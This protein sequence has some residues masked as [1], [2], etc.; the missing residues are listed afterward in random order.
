MRGFIIPVG[1]AESKIG[2]PL[3][4][5]RFVRLCGGRDAR[6]V[7]I[8]TASSLADTGERYEALFRELGA[9]RV[10]VL[11][12]ETRADCEDAER[13]ATLENA[14]GI[15]LTGGN[16]LRLATTLGGTSVARGDPAAQRGRACTWPA[17]RPG[18]AFL[19]E[20]MIAI[21]EEGSTPHSGDRDP[22]P[23]AGSYQPRRYR[24]TFPAARPAGPAAH[25]ARVQPV[26]AS[27]SGW[28]RTRQR[29][30]G[31]MTRWRWWAAMP[32]PSSTP[33]TW[34]SPPWTRR[35]RATRSA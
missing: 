9:K 18:A 34:S 29:S 24:P 21:G 25:G 28:T 33:P 4:L 8:P 5:K 20:H 3:I 30:S 14:R 22:L 23:G 6:I 15:F 10:D 13:L 1:G 27:G 16:Q 35:R 17:P 31:R 32:S 2:S 11:D 26:R 19:S 12:F 7:V